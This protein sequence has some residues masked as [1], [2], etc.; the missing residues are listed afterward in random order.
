[1]GSESCTIVQVN[2][3]KLTLFFSFFFFNWG[4]FIFVVGIWSWGVHHE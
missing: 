1:M 2:I 3:P 4:G